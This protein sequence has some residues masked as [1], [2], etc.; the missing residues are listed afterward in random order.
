MWTAIDWWNAAETTL[1][2]R[3]RLCDRLGWPR[4]YA[5]GE[6]DREW[7]TPE[8]Y[9]QLKRVPLEWLDEIDAQEV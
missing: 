7:L 3:Q 8:Q 6:A 5:E 9:A 2:A 1:D 4:Q